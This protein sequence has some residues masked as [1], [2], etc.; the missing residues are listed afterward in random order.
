MMAFYFKT[1]FD[2]PCLKDG[3]FFEKDLQYT[4]FIRCPFIF[5][6]ICNIP[7]LQDGPLLLRKFII[8]AVYKMSLFSKKFIIYP[9][10]KTS[11]KFQRD[12]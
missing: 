2:V 11:F 9:V 7:C 1:I 6:E 12:L 10:Y 8:Y 5:K 3:N 4:L